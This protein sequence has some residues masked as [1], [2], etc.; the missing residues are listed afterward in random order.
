MAV[1][2]VTKARK[3]SPVAA[4]PEQVARAGRCGGRSCRMKSCKRSYRAKGY[5]GVHYRQWRNGQFGRARYK[6]CGDK[7]CTNAMA[8]GRH[9]FCEEHYQNYYV[10]GIEQAKVA[11]PEKPAAKPQAASA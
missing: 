9:G 3:K 8:V 2:K 7:T 11:A 1:K 5:C 4:K 10:K 6:H